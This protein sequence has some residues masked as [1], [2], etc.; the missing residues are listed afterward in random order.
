[1]FLLIKNFVFQVVNGIVVFCCS[2][3]SLLSHPVFYS[4]ALSLS[5]SYTLMYITEHHLLHLHC[6]N[7][8]IQQFSFCYLSVYIYNYQ[9]TQLQYCPLRSSIH[10]YETCGC[11]SIISHCLEF[12]TTNFFVTNFYDKP[13]WPYTWSWLQ[14]LGTY[15]CLKI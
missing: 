13:S 12:F 15:C 8:H 11:I 14:T 6:P 7:S 1:M 5:L 10:S 4:L 3:P 2:L 9:C